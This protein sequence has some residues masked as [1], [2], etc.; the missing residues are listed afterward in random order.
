M[1]SFL[2]KLRWLGI[3]GP[4]VYVLLV[5]LLVRWLY[6]VPLDHETSHL[7]L[8]GLLGVGAGA[9]NETAQMVTWVSCAGNGRGEVRRGGSG[10]WDA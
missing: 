3:L 2:S 6:P 10:E 5:D 7:A 4:V 8:I 9:G 1:D